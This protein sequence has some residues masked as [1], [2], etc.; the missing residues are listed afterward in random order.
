MA[1]DSRDKR[2]S[3]IAVGLSWRT[4]YPVADGSINEGDRQQSAGWYRGILAAEL[5]IK[6]PWHLFFQTETF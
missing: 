6:V 4:V 5:D 2:A 1:L 3:A